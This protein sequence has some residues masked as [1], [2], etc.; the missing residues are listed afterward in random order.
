[1]TPTVAKM[2]TVTVVP[3][4]TCL[5]EHR[6]HWKRNAHMPVP[7]DG[8]FADVKHTTLSE[9]A[10]V[11]EAT[12]CLKC[13][14]APCQLS[15]PTHIDVKAFISAIAGKNYYGAAQQILSDNPLGLSCGAARRGAAGGPRCLR[16]AIDLDGV[17]FWLRCSLGSLLLV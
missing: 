4:T 13:V 5:T 12:R 1:M 2:N 17:W 14:D 15:C 9:S 10:A 7:L 11:M 6:P 8:N 3:T 16:F